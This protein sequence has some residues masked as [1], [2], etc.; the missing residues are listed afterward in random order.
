MGIFELVAEWMFRVVALHGSEE[1]SLFNTHSICIVF[2]VSPSGP[3]FVAMARILR[4]VT[5][6][7][8]TGRE[9]VKRKV[10]A[11]ITKYEFV[12]T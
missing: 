3:V 11:C 5:V 12:L 1:S 7:A 10:A 6:L 8:E 4:A 9:R 2:M